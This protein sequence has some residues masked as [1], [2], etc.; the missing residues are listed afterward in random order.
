MFPALAAELG[1]P[2]VHVGQE[3]FFE[4]GHQRVSE[5][6]SGF[7]GDHRPAVGLSSH[8]PEQAL[9]AVPGVRGA[10]TFVFTGPGPAGFLRGPEFVAV[11]AQ[12]PRRK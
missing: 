11:R 1:A 9:R 10:L 7:D 3:D 4:A 8:A 5:L 12:A 6:W 2:C